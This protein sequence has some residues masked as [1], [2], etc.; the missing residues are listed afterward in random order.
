M[1]SNKIIF[2]ISL[3]IFVLA[4]IGAVLNSIINY[5][6]VVST[7]KTLGYPIYLIQLLGVAQLIGLAIIILNKDQF[8]VEWVYAGFF[9]NFILGAIAHLVANSGNG[10]SAVVCLIILMV[11]YVQAKKFRAFKKE[12]IRIENS[13]FTNKVSV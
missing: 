9:M 7:F 6:S 13:S 1:K 2:G 5:D 3:G 8:L 12:N 11:T 10:A 4:V